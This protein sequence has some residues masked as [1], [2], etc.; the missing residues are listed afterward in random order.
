MKSTII[1]FQ[2]NILH[3]GVILKGLMLQIQGILRTEKC[4]AMD[5]QIWGYDH[6]NTGI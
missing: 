2:G 5:P 1:P 3:F 4:G 6:M